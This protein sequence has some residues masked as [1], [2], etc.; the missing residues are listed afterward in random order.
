MWDAHDSG[1]A[2]PT[3]SRNHGKN[4][5][6][7]VDEIVPIRVCQQRRGGMAQRHIV[8]QQHSQNSQ[9][10]KGIKRFQTSALRRDRD[11]H[12]LCH[13]SER[14]RG[15]KARPS[16]QIGEQKLVR[17]VNTTVCAAHETQNK[18]EQKREHSK[19]TM[20]RGRGFGRC[21]KFQFRERRGRQLGRGDV[22][23]RGGY[24]FL[25]RR[26]GC[27]HGRGHTGH[28]ITSVTRSLS[29]P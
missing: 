21:D 3:I 17:M 8:D 13:D 11:F 20:P 10:A 24:A 6:G 15:G 1:R 27:G 5:V 2:T 19:K 16:L 18:P 22:V 4:H 28:K 14:P 26:F 9:P 7:E 23:G 29:A 12:P 25:G